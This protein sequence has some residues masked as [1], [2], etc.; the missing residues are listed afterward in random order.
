MPEQEFP[1]PAPPG[2]AGWLRLVLRL[3]PLLVLNF[4]GL[5]VLLLLR[6]LERPLCGQHRPVTGRQVQLV[7]LLSLRILGLRLSTRGRPMREGGAVV[8]NH[9]SWL[10]IYVLNAAQRVY[11]VAKSEVASWAG[12][13]W[14]ARSTGTVFIRRDRREARAQTKLFRDRMGLG[15]KLL[16]F[17]EGTSTDNMRVLPFKSTLFDAFFDPELRPKLHIQP[18]TVIYH[19]PYGADPRFYGWFGEMGFGGHVIQILSARRGGSVEVIWH[20]ALA[21]ADLADRKQMAAAAEAA[22]RGAMPPERQIS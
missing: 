21:A 12:I 4:G 9:S 8:A 2:L 6:L 11:F 22:V 16:F 1:D 5:I 20:P 15:H 3:I 19:A 7:C 17:P 13:G 10:D 18:I 14:L